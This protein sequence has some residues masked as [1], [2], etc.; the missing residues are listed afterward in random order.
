MTHYLYLGSVVLFRV[1]AVLSLLWGTFL[2]LMSMPM[3]FQPDVGLI[4]TW[5]TFIP[6]IISLV[7]W[8]LAKPI[9]RLVTSGLD[10]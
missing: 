5:P 6:V 4:A 8:F 10:H 9:A 3:T 2:V 7:L 1:L